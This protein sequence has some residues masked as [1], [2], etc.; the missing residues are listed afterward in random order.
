MCR[1]FIVIGLLIGIAS[2]LPGQEISKKQQREID[3]IESLISKAGK[4][5]QAGNLDRSVSIIDKAQSEMLAM[6][7]DASEELLG[8]LQPQFVRLQTAH[9]LL[10]EAGQT[11]EPLPEKLVA[12]QAAPTE[13]MTDDATP[14][15]MQGVSFTRQVAPILVARC[16]RC[17]VDQ[18]RGQ[19]SSASYAALMSSTHV[20]PGMA[21][22]S[23][24]I[25]VIANGEMPPGG[26]LEPADVQ[27]LGTWIAEG[28]KFDGD[29][30]DTNLKQ[31]NVAAPATMDAP[32]M[33]AK[34]SGEE[35]VSF[36]ADIA[37][38]LLANCGICH[39]DT[40]RP[41]AN[42]SMATF[43]SLLEGGNAG[44][45]A[46]KPGNPAG[47][48][49]LTRIRADG[50]EM[51]PPD[52][53]LSDAD[54]A[55]IE[56]WIREGAVI[57]PLLRSLRMHEIAAVAKAGSMNN[58]ELKEYRRERSADIWKLVMSDQQ[59]DTFDSDHL[60]VVG[61]PTSARLSE[62]AT[63]AEE[64]IT[65]VQRMLR[66]KEEPFIRGN[67]TLFVLE[68]RY[69]LSEFG[70][71]AERIDLPSGLR[72]YWRHS[73]VDAYGVV[74]IPADEPLE[75]SAA[76]LT[77]Q[78]TA[79]HIADLSP[80]IPDWFCDGVALWTASKIHRDLAETRQWDDA[81]AAAAAS[82]KRPDDF[83][84]ERMPEDQA[85]LVSFLFIK[86]L[87]EKTGQFNKLMNRLRDH[88][89]FAI[90]FRQVYGST[91]AEMLR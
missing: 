6:T 84:M 66:S 1:F 89:D 23:R 17:H 54:I 19:F 77:R 73:V 27:T 81:G 57:E 30:A 47:S 52:G 3:Q 25:E 49:L 18:S 75:Q 87:G 65:T 48:N 38:I 88:E 40:P 34:P 16:G 32:S 37:P 79:L 33:T 36:G 60:M 90:V 51:M 15:A 2:P 43:R 80:T 13:S 71:M 58:E 11:L 20:S 8:G 91:P 64:S 46:I 82:M 63:M 74:L 72:G 5:F 22:Q 39:I 78:I 59:T 55:K 67:G 31:M 26:S 44:G 7:E 12:T 21:E 10:T 68:K 83:L 50:P 69:D 56:T 41:P 14:D 70:K 29:A 4:Q 24:L 62:I 9:R 35:T 42:F 45:A 28:A 76:N 53:K 86:R 85:A 61:T